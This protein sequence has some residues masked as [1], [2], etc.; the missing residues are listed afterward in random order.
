M[1]QRWLD[2]LHPRLT[3]RRQLIATITGVHMLLMVSF[4]YDLVDR[5]QQFLLE[6]ARARILYQAQVLAASSVPQLITRDLSGL[7]EIFE[8]VSRDKSIRFASLTNQDG[9][10]IAHS[11]SRRVMQLV[12]DAHRRSV[13]QG[14]R[15]PVV[16]YETVGGIEAAA[17]V[18]VDDHLLG[19]AWV[20]ADLSQDQAQIL[21]LRRTGV[22][23][24]LIAVIS[25]AVFAIILASA[26]TRQLR[27]LMAGTGRLA[28]DRLDEPV[29]VV[30]D[31]EV[32]V[33]A[34]AFNEAMA[35]LGQQRSE[36]V[37][38]HD[39]LEAEVAVRRRAEH[40]LLTANRAIL[41]A[42]ESLRQFAYAASHDL[43]EPLRSVAG[44]SELL[45]RRYAGRLD[46]DADV[47]IGFIHSG[48]RRMENLIKALLDYSRAGAPGGEPAHDV[49]T[50][51][52]LR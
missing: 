50:Q 33:V 49:D 3:L 8:S 11:D 2:R 42:N 39:A 1:I 36:L 48:A 9:R 7:K 4:V 15:K 27:L 43:Q 22:I 47:F 30:T 28:E 12:S 44:Y 45:R 17:P 26:I 6:R 52:T 10:I 21:G 19:W 24:T 32:G 16:V 23:Y 37:R 46:D 20:A 18:M 38:A 5:Q 14:D 34:A 25:G 41:N 40:E 51:E 35:K 29:P 13:M 31:N